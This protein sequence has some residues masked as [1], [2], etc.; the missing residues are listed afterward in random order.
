MAAD[1]SCRLGWLSAVDVARV[2]TLLLAAGLPVVPPA[3]SA[4]EFLRHMA[5]DKKVKDGKLKLVLMEA[6]GAA[7]VSGAPEGLLRETLAQGERLGV[8]S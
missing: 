6:L 1:L 7:V 2:R 8:G 3:M 5:V 4:D